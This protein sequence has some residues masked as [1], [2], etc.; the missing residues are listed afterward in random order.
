MER[1][2]PNPRSLRHSIVGQRPIPGPPTRLASFQP[3]WSVN[4]LAQAA[5]LVALA[6]ANYLPKA[7]QAV[8]QSKEFLTEHLTSLELT[9][10]PSSANFLLVQVG[11]GTIMRDKLLQRGLVVRDCAS[12][13]IADCIRIGIRSLPDCERLAA[14][15][16]ETV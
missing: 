16:G 2:G 3:D 11:N 8:N 4:S 9:V 15:M 6:D 13:G 12:F 14:A 10:L 1:P 7:R 5:G